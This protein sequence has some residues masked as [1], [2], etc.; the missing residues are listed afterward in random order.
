[1]YGSGPQ[2]TA[3]LIG[4]AI[5]TEIIAVAVFEVIGLTLQQK[6]A[7]MVGQKDLSIP[8][9]SQVE[10]HTLLPEYVARPHETQV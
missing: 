1:M 10:A 2:Y 5:V 7:H 9:Y 6:P 8:L 4:M 3:F